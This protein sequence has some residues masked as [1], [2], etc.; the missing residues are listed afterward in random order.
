M[1]VRGVFARAMPDAIKL[2]NQRFG[3]NKSCLKMQKTGHTGH[4][5]ALR[6]MSG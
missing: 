3:M 2:Y 1:F 6:D 4:F 5:S